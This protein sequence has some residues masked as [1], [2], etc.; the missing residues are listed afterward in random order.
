MYYKSPFLKAT[1]L[2]ILAIVYCILINFNLLPGQKLYSVSLFNHA[3]TLPPHGFS[4]PLHPGIDFGLSKRLK[5]KAQTTS[6]IHWKV[7]YY[8][9]RLVHQ[10]IQVYGEYN[11]QYTILK[12]F[13][14]SWSG[15]LG[16]LHTIELH[17]KFKLNKEGNY[18]RAGRFG[19]PHAQI[20]LST[21]VFYKLPSFTPFIQYRVR[22]VSPFVK[23]YVPFLPN[24]SLH[25]GTY[26]YLN[27]KD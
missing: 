12:N 23:S 20:S 18:D 24:T 16:Y 7:G 26:Y 27:T 19:K 4:G 1:F 5:E 25:L 11:K 10:G 14:L 8:Y 2:K 17:E 6:F 3:T 15:G 13:G 22:M 21:G 9:H